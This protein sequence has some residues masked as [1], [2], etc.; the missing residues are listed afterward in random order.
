MKIKVNTSEFLKAIHAVEGVISAR[1]I[2]SVLS[3]LKLEA[4]TSSVSISA[5]D[6]EISIKTSLNAQVEK[7]GDISLPAKQ[8]SSIFKTIHFEEA[9]LST[10]DSDADSSIT[11]IT[12]ATKKNDYKNKLNGMDAE[13]IKTIPKVDASNISDFPTAMFAEMIRKTSYAIA[14]E[15][16]RYIFNGLFMVPK[17]D[18]LVFAVTDGRRLCKIERPLST[19]LKFKDSVIIP[20]KAIREISKMIATA[21]TGKIGIIDNQ[22]YVNANQI[23][24]LCKL[25]EGNFPNY[26]QVIPKSSKFSAVIPKEGFQIYLRQALIAAEEPT[27]QIRLT[28]TKNNINFYA[29]TQGVNE[30]SIN[31]PIDYSGDEVTVA[32]KGEYLS[33][34]F[35]SI[36]DNEFRIEFS[37]SSSPVVF[38]DPSDPDFI[39][40]IMPMKI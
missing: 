25:I 5:T 20:S 14:H 18:K 40:V 32:F 13:E 16:Q 31:M 35:K 36:D 19:T 23:E 30:V 1:E 21:E 22:I 15:D 37:D 8:L 11:Y 39:S 24:L 12:D 34:V 26:E 9:L 27:R 10:E 17:G 2:R 33:D 38:K 28:F 6:L 29:Q 4:E 7:S 3:N